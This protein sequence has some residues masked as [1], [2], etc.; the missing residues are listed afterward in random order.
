MKANVSVLAAGQR[1][2]G[3]PVGFHFKGPT[4]LSQAHLQP[5]KPCSHHSGRGRT[6]TTTPSPHHKAFLPKGR[7]GLRSRIQPKTPGSPNNRHWRTERQSH[8]MSA[9]RTST[10][11]FLLEP[12]PTRSMP[13]PSQVT[14][15][16]YNRHSHLGIHTT[17]AQRAPLGII[18]VL[19]LITN[20]LKYKKIKLHICALT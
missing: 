12:Q 13:P 4:R 5:V 19:C 16:S 2:A 11:G 10:A 9:H 6:S 17:Y 18:L 3:V 20:L 15:A 8:R 1:W 7:N 14:Q